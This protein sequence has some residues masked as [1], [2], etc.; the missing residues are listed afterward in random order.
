M[1]KIKLIIVCCLIPVFALCALVLW[2]AKEKQDYRQRVILAQEIRKVMNL[3]MFDLRE[4]R[5]GSVQGVPADGQWHDRIAF[6]HSGGP[7]EYSLKDGHV[8]R[9]SDG[10]GTPVADHIASLR[11][12]RQAVD[13]A[14]A[15]VQI[16]ARDKIS[17]VSNFKI[18]MQD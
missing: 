4:T 13:G 6:E 2:K 15:E 7:I 10:R 9:F 3:M 8:S 17:L 16:Q 18:R 5:Q 11:M 1:P 14:I 12:R